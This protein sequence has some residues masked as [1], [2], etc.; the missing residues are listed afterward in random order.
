MKI[1]KRTE[2]TLI[3][4]DRPWLIGA[5]MIVF[6][7]AFGGAGLFLVTSGEWFGLIFMFFGFVF[8]PLLFSFFVRRVQA[9]FYRPENWLELRRKTLFGQSRARFDLRDV[10]RATVETTT[11]S[12]GGTLYRVALEMESGGIAGR[13]PLTTAYSNVGDHRGVAAAINEWLG[14]SSS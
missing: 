7:L 9:V 13:K 14:V 4:E 3:V 2:H 11:G 1:R 5:M 10:R 8:A 6:V 12:K